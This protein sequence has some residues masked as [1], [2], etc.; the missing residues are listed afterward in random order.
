MHQRIYESACACVCIHPCTCVDV[1]R[2][3]FEG[4]CLIS[5]SSPP[6]TIVSTRQCKW[7]GCTEKHI[8][9]IGNDRHFCA[10][11]VVEAI[12]A[13]MVSEGSRASWARGC[14]V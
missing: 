4:P 13:V 11:H 14:P 3:A 12:N 1:C 10:Q 2:G 7:Q 5:V 6:P 9:S 8:K